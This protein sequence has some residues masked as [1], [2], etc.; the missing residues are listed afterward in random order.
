MFIPRLRTAL[1]LLAG[2]AA[3]AGIGWLPISGRASEP[4]ASIA[5]REPKPN[6]AE[7]PPVEFARLQELIRPHPGES[8][9]AELPWES[10][11]SVARKKAAAAGKLVFILGAG[12][13]P[14]T[15]FC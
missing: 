3:L 2:W 4:T 1:G 9:W 14:A 15:G 6:E 8:R 11:L 12:S 7:A 10:S 13:G 5:P